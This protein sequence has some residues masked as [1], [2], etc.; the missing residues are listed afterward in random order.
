MFLR[1]HERYERERERARSASNQSAV[2][3][4]RLYFCPRSRVC[5]SAG[6]RTDWWERSP[7][8]TNR[9]NC[10]DSKHK[11]H[12]FYNDFS[13]DHRLPSLVACY[14]SYNKV[15]MFVVSVWHMLCTTE[16][17]FVEHSTIVSKVPCIPGGFSW[18]LSIEQINREL[19][20]NAVFF[21][22]RYSRTTKS[23]HKFV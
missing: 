18:A 17:G 19:N 9:L 23:C 5:G 10:F 4:L 15:A 16:S 20:V 11:Q 7:Q 8:L 21:V 22:I 6:L 14:E 13:S 1:A 2:T 12:T 3:L